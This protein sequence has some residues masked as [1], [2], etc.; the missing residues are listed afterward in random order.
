[1]RQR[2][3]ALKLFAFLMMAV[4]LSFPVQAALLQ[5]PANLLKSLTWLNILV[6]FLCAGLAW[7]AF[8]VHR[9]LRYL[10][11]I[12]LAAVIFNNWWVGHVGLDFNW[13]QTTLAS[14]GFAS[15][16][17]F[18]LEKKT[19]Q[20]VSDPK[21]KWWSVAP[22]KQLAVPVIL[23]PWR[24]GDKIHKTSFDVS[25]S[26]IFVQGIQ[27]DEMTQYKIGEK[28]EIR[29]QLDALSEINC[30]AKLVRMTPG[31]GHYPPGIGFCFEGLDETQKELLKKLSQQR[32]G[33]DGLFLRSIVW[34]RVRK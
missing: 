9:S 26:G 16:Y 7:S 25:D 15:L 1:M 33:L 24:R 31:Q 6:A 8:H 12:T 10:L 4:A 23:S 34:I 14:L 21:R 13:I 18:L 11:V 30:S 27:D 22:R 2:P 32:T 5:D 19:Y 17:G 3:W 29:M 20:V 28:F